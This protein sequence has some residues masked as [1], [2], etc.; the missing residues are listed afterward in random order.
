MYYLYIY[1]ITDLWIYVSPFTVIYNNY[2]IFK[3][4]ILFIIIC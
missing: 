4:Y 1:N 3:I 2:I